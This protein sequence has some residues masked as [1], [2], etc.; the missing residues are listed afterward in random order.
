MAV[1]SSLWAS[2]SIA[3]RQSVRARSIASTGGTGGA[4]GAGF[5]SGVPSA[6]TGAGAGA[7]AVAGAGVGA[8]AEVG[9]GVGDDRTC[10]TGTSGSTAGV[11]G[12]T[13]RAD[14]SL[15]ETDAGEVGAGVPRGRVKS[16]HFTWTIAHVRYA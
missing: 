6:T 7:G 1:A 13:G 11:A 2:A 3:C 16:F 8:G 4:T 5:A 12:S 15:I 14:E 10:A 9:V